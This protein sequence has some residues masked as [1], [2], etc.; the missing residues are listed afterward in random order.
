MNNLATAANMADVA[1]EYH[2]A[3][4]AGTDEYHTLLGIGRLAQ[5]RGRMMRGHSF[6]GS[7]HARKEKATRARHRQRVMRSISSSCPSRSTEMLLTK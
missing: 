7:A 4:A 2:A 3:R 1:A 6:G 5:Q